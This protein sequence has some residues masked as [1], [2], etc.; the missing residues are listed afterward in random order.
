MAQLAAPSVGPLRRPDAQTRAGRPGDL[1][2]FAHPDDVSAK[3]EASPRQG[4]TLRLF[5]SKRGPLSG[6]S[7]TWWLVGPARLGMLRRR[8]TCRRPGHLGSIAAARNDRIV[9]AST[10][11]RR[12][13]PAHSA[14]AS[15][16][17]AAEGAPRIGSSR[18]GWGARGRRAA[19]RR[20]GA[21]WA[22][23]RQRPLHRPRGSRPGAR[24]AVPRRGDRRRTDQHRVRSSRIGQ[25]SARRRLRRRPRRSP[26]D[27]DE[28]RF[29]LDA[30]ARRDRSAVVQRRRRSLDGRRGPGVMRPSL[31]HPP[32]EV[33]RPDE[34]WIDV[35]AATQ[36]LVA[37]EGARPV[38]ATLVSTGRMSDTP[39]PPGVHRIWAK[40][41]TSSMGNVASERRG[42]ALPALSRTVPH[43]FQFFDKARRLARDV[44]ARRLRSR[45]EPRLRQPGDERRALA[46]RLHRAQAPR[47][48]GG[49]VP[50]AARSWHVRSSQ[51]A[52]VRALVEL[53]AW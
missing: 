19:Q 26:G 15:L 1:V 20:G 33:T 29:Q 2:L 48:L 37:Y 24:I 36:T 13:L 45:P 46:L 47:R 32:A 34:R 17:S 18:S 35:E 39:T 42:R 52:S 5:G 11:L 53:V 49:R 51:V 38:F 30:R 43:T 28:A 50:Y 8:R 25:A 14:Y 6:C 3:S 23:D 22:R 31:A 27:F 21:R 10:S 44:L 12:P 40:L 41:L 16:E 9:P 7:G 4:S